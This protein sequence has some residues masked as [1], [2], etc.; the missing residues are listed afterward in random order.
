MTIVGTSLATKSV[1][2]D[3]QGSTIFEKTK[4][5]RT[6]MLLR[7]G[8]QCPRTQKKTTTTTQTM[9]EEIPWKM[10]RELSDIFDVLLKT[11]IMNTLFETLKKLE[12]SASSAMPCNKMLEKDPP[13]QNDRSPCAFE[14]QS[15]I[16]KWKLVNN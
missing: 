4:K 13:A 12:R 14:Q 3:W 2:E 1:F 7:G 9:E 10:A 11:K 16:W 5:K 8:P 15:V 6:C